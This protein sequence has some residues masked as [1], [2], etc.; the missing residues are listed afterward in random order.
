MRRVYGG[1]RGEGCVYLMEGEEG[2]GEGEEGR[3]GCLP[4]GQLHLN[5]LIRSSQIPP[6]LHGL[7]SHSSI[8][9]SHRVPL[10]PVKYQN[11]NLLLNTQ[12]V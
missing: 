2:R 6:F 7:L 5:L 12:D 9:C 4:D 8:L 1:G 3:R 10:Y 11:N